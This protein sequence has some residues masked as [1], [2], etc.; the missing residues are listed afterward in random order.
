SSRSRHTKSKRDWSSDVCSSDLHVY[1]FTPDDAVAS[2]QLSGLASLLLPA[3]NG[4]IDSMRLALQLTVEQQHGIASDDNVIG[5]FRGDL[6]RLGNSQLRH[7]LSWG[8]V[9]ERINQRC[10]IHVRRA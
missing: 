3:S 9:T 1:L 5:E 10:F 6:F 2:E 8:S 4:G 7:N